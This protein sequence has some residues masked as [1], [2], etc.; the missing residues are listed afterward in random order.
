MYISANFITM[1]EETEL[2]TFEM[3]QQAMPEGVVNSG[4]NIEG[5]VYFEK[6]PEE[7]DRV[8]LRTDLVNARTGQEF[9]EVRIPYDVQ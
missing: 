8:V 9:A 5:W 4:G 7:K 2:P 1:S 3:L 6:V